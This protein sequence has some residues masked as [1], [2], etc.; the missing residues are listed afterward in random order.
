MN[1]Y[2]V[3]LL[4]EVEGG[5]RY[6]I[7][8]EYRARDAELAVRKAIQSERNVVRQRYPDSNFVIEIVENGTRFADL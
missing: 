8:D 4:V 1:A 7:E 6:I 2:T 5:H 3:T